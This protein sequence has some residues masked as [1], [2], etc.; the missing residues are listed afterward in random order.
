MFNKFLICFTLILLF[1]Y[2]AI[3]HN[4]RNIKIKRTRKTR[5]DLLDSILKYIFILLNILR[6]K[7]RLKRPI[8]QSF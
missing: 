8:S 2:N 7:R 6:L 3:K 4:A 1:Y 5:L